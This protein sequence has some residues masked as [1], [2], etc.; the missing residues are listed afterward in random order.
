MAAP[1]LPNTPSS[2][3]GPA[4]A[5]SSP[6]TPLSP[7]SESR[8]Q[9]RIAHLLTL[10]GALLSEIS[11][12]QAAGQGGALNPA[13]AEAARQKGL[14]DKL[15]SE[16]YIHTMRRVQANLQYLMYKQ[17]PDG[18]TKQLPGPA[19]MTPPP[20]LG[21][22]LREEYERLRELFP[23]WNGIDARGGVGTPG[24][25]NSA[26]GQGQGQPHQPQ[27]QGMQQG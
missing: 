5:G 15:A 12:L 20:H 23:G 27:S 7:A 22:K 14:P 11:V 6:K 2:A 10:N 3:T 25:Q 17:Q 19:V 21:E 4:G 18:G 16:D 26:G 1:P 13:Q 9:Q 8:E 24:R